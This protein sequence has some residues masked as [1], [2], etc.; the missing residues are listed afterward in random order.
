MTGA[1]QRGRWLI[2]D[3]L[4][5]A[6]LDDALGVLSSYLSGLPVT[7]A[8]GEATAPARWRVVA[9]A[10]QTLGGSP[11]LV[12]RF[13]HV[14]IPSPGDTGM[15]AQIEAAAGGD[16][17]AA[18]AVKRLLPVRELGPVGAGAFLA[19]TRLAVARNAAAPADER[20]LAREAL[21]AHITPLL[22]PLD[23]EARRRLAALTG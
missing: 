5:R 19:A 7:L 15:A 6:P 20:T 1:A 4:D 9:T 10:G 3:E 16:A 12:G 23:E 13:A 18:A 11:A 22:G 2:A 17:T 21:A 8:D 14:R